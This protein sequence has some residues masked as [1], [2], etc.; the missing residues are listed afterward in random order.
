MT[1]TTASDEINDHLFGVAGLSFQLRVLARTRH[2]VVDY[3]NQFEQTYGHVEPDYVKPDHGEACG[4]SFIGRV[5][6]L[7]RSDCV[8]PRIRFPTPKPSTN[9][10]AEMCSGWVVMIPL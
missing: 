9:F 10:S 8:W 5:A 3:V 7:V 2:R 6:I 4:I 1:S